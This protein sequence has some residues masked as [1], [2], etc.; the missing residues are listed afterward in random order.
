MTRSTTIRERQ[1]RQTV[2]LQ[3]KGPLVAGPRG[4]RI[5]GRVRRACEGGARVVVLDL[6]AVP[7]IDGGGIGLLLVCRQIARRRGVALRVA[8][9]RGLVRAMLHLSAL[10]G[11]LQT[12]RE[13]RP[14][15]RGEAGHDIPLLLSA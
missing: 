10:L 7:L 8:R 11:P 12:G 15:D 6:Q 2:S 4:D 14:L 1:S 9:A 5:L 13:P 3:L